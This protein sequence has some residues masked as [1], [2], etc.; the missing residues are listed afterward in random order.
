MIAEAPTTLAAVRA[1]AVALRADVR[2]FCTSDV[3]AGLRERSE[4]HQVLS[5]E[6]YVSWMTLLRD[7][8]WLTAHWSV[9]DGG[10]GWSVV[11]RFAFEDELA[12]LGMPWIIPMGIKYVGP[13]I[14]RYGSPE[15]KARFLPGIENATEWWAQGFSEP[16]AGSDLAGVSTTAEREGDHYRVNGQK[17]W[18]TYAQW[19]DW[20]FTLVR[21]TRTARP[22][23]GISFLLIDLKSPGVTVKPI[24]TMDGYHHLNEVW[25]DDVIVPV[26]NRVGEEN[27][28]WDQSK[29]L[30][31]N[32]RTAGS[33]VGNAAHAL[34]RLK[35]LPVEGRPLLQ[36]RIAEFDLRLMTLEIT[37]DAMVER[38]WS[39]AETGIEPSLIKIRAGELYQQVAEATIEALG[40]A[41]VAYDV[42]AVH[43]A[44]P[45]PL[46]PIDAGGI[47]KDHLYRRAS[48]IYGG[49]TEVQRN[50]IARTVLGLG[51]ER[52]A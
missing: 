37:A 43:A 22:Q 23:Q 20:M 29:F 24:P 28:G 49:T 10:L 26:G 2:S 36:H 47:I 48:T 5:R 19:A 16:G 32:E 6:D 21:T 17:V 41:G 38:M 18:T 50:I 52:N 11:E 33:M 1:A 40:A 25:L 44:T 8:G 42:E 30:L 46:P 39:G 45:Q 35:Q 4:R 13:V 27:T 14:S 12:R 7:R 3:P 9:A 34:H 51:A 15:Q 31:K